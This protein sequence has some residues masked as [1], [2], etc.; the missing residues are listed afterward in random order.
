ML[1]QINSHLASVDNSNEVH[2]AT[3]TKKKKN[4]AKRRRELVGEKKV[5]NVWGKRE[6][7]RWV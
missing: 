6:D 1:L 5:I 3:R 2:W 4:E 7:S